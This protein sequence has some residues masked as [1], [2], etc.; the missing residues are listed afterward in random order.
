VIEYALLTVKTS[1]EALLLSIGSWIDSTFY[2][3]RGFLPQF[4]AGLNFGAIFGNPWV[5]VL[6]A[7][8]VLLI[9]LEVRR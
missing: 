6:I 2:A 9:L 5:L 7:G 3:L 4:D 1:L 8:L